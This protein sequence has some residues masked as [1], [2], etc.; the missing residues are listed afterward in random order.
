MNKPTY[1]Y[2]RYKPIEEACWYDLKTRKI[3]LVGS[4]RQEQ[5]SY[6]GFISLHISNITTVSQILVCA[7]LPCRGFHKCT[8][9]GKQAQR[10]KE[11]PLPLFPLVDRRTAGGRRPSPVPPPVGG[12]T[13]EDPGPC[14]QDRNS[15]SGRAEI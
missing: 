10:G 4:Y 14:C 7:V 9:V 15:Q 3:I 11:I 8:T 1:T 13:G 2:E 5:G 12:G 6:T